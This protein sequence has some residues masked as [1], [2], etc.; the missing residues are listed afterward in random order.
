MGNKS[1]FY[2]EKEVNAE[3]CSDCKINPVYHQEYGWC[4]DCGPPDLILLN[5]EEN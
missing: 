5:D 3:I 2:K 4:K 1:N